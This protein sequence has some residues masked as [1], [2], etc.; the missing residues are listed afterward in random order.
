MK[1]IPLLPGSRAIIRVGGCVLSGVVVLVMTTASHGQECV[2]CHSDTLGAL[3]GS[4]HHVQGVELNGRHCYAC[5]WEAT[6]EGGVDAR[7]HSGKKSKGAGINL[8][9]WNAGKRPTVFTPQST[10]LEFQPSLIGTPRERGEI[11]KI[12]KHCLSCHNDQANDSRP[13]PG[14]SNR[15]RQYAWDGQSVAARYSQQ[16]AT[17][18]GKYSTAQTNRKIRV[19]KSFSAHGNAAA[20]QGGWTAASGYDGDMPITRGGPRAKN[21]ECFDCHNSHG[22]TTT[23]VTTSYRTFDGSRGG[24]LLKQTQAGRGGYRMTYQPSSNQDKSSHNPYNSGAGLCF[25]CHETAQAGVTPWGYQSTFGAEQPIMGYKDTLRF[26]P[27]AKGSTARFAG[28]HTH[29]EI[30]SSHLKAGKFLNY[31]TQGRIDGLCTPCHDPHGVSPTLGDAMPYAIPLLKGTWLASP[32]R[33]DAPPAIMPTRGAYAGKTGN[34]AMSWDKGDLK[35]GTN[36]GQTPMSYNTDRNTFGEGMYIKETDVQF[37][38]LCL[39]CH[40][41]EKFTGN[42][43]DLVHRAVKGWGANREHA[44]PCSKCHQSH[45]SGLPRLMQTNCLESGPSGLRDSGAA[46]WFPGKQ[47]SG[48]RVVSQSRVSTSTKKPVKES[49]VGCHVRRAGNRGNAPA[50]PPVQWNKV[51]PW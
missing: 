38:G 51:N 13:F 34:M 6:A 19:V 11:A 33:E 42:R 15:P 4:S 12:T 2:D 9:I 48:N 45:N 29:T 43:N 40:H 49:V 16:G 32:Y 1:I 30:A 20:N 18:W 8:V 14:D 31:S 37:G 28:R 24:G 25:D 23:G 5:H 21:V 47:E 27:G 36:D 46:P 3:K 7:Y 35:G 17:T 41:K 39:K 10:A 26:G 22:S 44:F 50:S